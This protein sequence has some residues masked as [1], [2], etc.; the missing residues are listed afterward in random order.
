MLL[1]GLRPAVLNPPRHP[2]SRQDRQCANPVLTANTR[3]GNKRPDRLTISQH[4]WSG[5]FN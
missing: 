5:L 3:N 1:E 2:S 4:S